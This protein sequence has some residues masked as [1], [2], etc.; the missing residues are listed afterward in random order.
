VKQGRTFVTNGP[1]LELTA[2]GALPGSEVRVAPKGPV[3]I[4]VRAWAPR[5]IGSPK[6]LEV[7]AHGRVIRSVESR[8]PNQAELALEFTVRPEAGQWITARVESHNGARAH[9]SPIYILAGGEDFKDRAQL[10]E[11]VAKRLRVL[12]Y[13][14]GKLR[15]EKFTRTYVVGELA[16]H[17]LRVQ[18]ARGRYRQL[19]QAK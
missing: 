19:L 1:M 15:D 3:R 5:A 10:P 4:R 14:E 16:K 8:N 7:V 9:T 2:N 12:E 18:D 6:R 13:I 11:L 17:N